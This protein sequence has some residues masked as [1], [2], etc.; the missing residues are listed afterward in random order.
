MSFFD[1]KHPCERFILNF[2][3]WPQDENIE[4]ES[5]PPDRIFQYKNIL[6]TVNNEILI[7]VIIN[8][9][10]RKISR[11]TS[12]IDEPGLPKYD[13]ELTSSAVPSE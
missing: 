2:L 11:T 5:L 13:G 10:Y 7:P 12:H 3:M 8:I 9:R 6:T 1:N 4:E